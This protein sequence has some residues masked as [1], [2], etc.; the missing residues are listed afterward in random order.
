MDTSTLNNQVIDM[1]LHK[2]APT[3]TFL[4]D[5]SQSNFKYGMKSFLLNALAK[6]SKVDPFSFCIS[7]KSSGV[8]GQQN[9]KPERL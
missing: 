2:D 4:Q 7:S 9:L 5:W 8:T 6:Q 1:Y 3:F